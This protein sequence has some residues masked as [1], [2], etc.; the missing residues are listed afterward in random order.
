MTDTISH[1]PG[2]RGGGEGACTPLCFTPG[3]NF[4][5]SFMLHPRGEGC[6]QKRP[7]SLAFRGVWPDR[8]H[9]K[10]YY[11]FANGDSYDGDYVAHGVFF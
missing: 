6:R 5:V 4:T 2:E 7:F 1:A 3:T 10:G 8:K 11:K 9:G